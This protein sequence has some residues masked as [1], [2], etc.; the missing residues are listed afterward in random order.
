MRM[1]QRVFPSFTLV[2]TNR[3]ESPALPDYYRSTRQEVYGP[4]VRNQASA[5]AFDAVRALD[6]RND[7][8]DYRCS[9]YL[10]PDIS[11]EGGSDDDIELDS[12]I[13]SLKE[14]DFDFTYSPLRGFINGD[15]DALGWVLSVPCSYDWKRADACSDNDELRGPE[16]AFACGIYIGDSDLVP[17]CPYPGKRKLPALCSSRNRIDPFK[18]SASESDNAKDLELSAWLE[19]EGTP[20]AKDPELGAFAWGAYIG[21]SDPAT[22]CPHPGK[23]KSAN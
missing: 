16:L 22:S 19:G 8:Y 15:T 12:V 1:L 2:M 14:E 5:I 9:D 6:A 10:L 21:D 7:I 18:S 13:Y 4:H 17:S 23:R 3:S 11:E 20:G